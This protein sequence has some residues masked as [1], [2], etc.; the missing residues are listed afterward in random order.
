[1]AKHAAAWDSSDAEGKKYLLAQGGKLF[2]LDAKEAARWKQASQ[3]VI[4]AYISKMEK[5]GINGKEIV[6]YILSLL[7]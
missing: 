6:D 3:P 1:M 5:M 7:K 4:K 2:K